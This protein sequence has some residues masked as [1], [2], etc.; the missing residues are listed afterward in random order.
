MA[1]LNLKPGDKVTIGYTRQN[2]K[3]ATLIKLRIETV[4]RLTK[5]LFICRGSVGESRYRRPNGIAVDN[6]SHILRIATPEDI[7]FIESKNAERAA[8]S[9]ATET[10]RELR[11]TLANLFKE[12]VHLETPI[13]G[14]GW[15]LVLHNL[16][17][18]RIRELAALMAEANKR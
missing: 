8:Q 7:A 17:E 5:T 13:S 4:E 18:D 9:K 10:E 6:Y 3:G 12:N 16:T 11:N 1:E 15:D 2:R 14:Q